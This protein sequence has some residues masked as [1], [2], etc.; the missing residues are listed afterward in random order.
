MDIQY[1]SEFIKLVEIGNFMEAADEL[2]ISQSTLSKHINALEKE[3]EVSLFDR[4]TRRVKLTE[5]GRA[6]LPY[7]VKIVQLQSEY[8][9]ALRVSSSKNCKITLA[10]TSQMVQYRVV[11]ALA[12]YKR[13]HFSDH[14]DII[15]EQ[16]D[17][18]KNL[19]HSKKADFIWSG[20][21]AEE[22]EDESFTR[23]PFLDDPMVALFPD[24]HPLAGRKTISLADLSGSSIVMQDRSSVEQNVFLEACRAQGLH[25]DVTSLPPGRIMMDFVR[26]NIGVAIMLRAPAANSSENGI[27]I[28]EISDSPLIHVSLIYLKKHAL[29]PAAKR[30]LTFI[31]EWV[32]E[33]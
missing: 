1:F 2:F 20:E 23:I 10:S 30:F 21:P 24:T 5:A 11:D 14:L 32:Q 7:A 27:S 9:S 17:N 3:L 31:Q 18:L 8:T 28:V 6:L 33:H 29:T 4:T 13:T 22:W 25:F 19:L 15:T 12:E 16:H 26:Q